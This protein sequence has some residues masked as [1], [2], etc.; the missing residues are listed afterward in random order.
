MISKE[1][2][3]E[4]LD[5]TIEA[6]NNNFAGLPSSPTIEGKNEA[7]ERLVKLFAL[8][9]VSWRSELLISFSEY[10]H[11]RDLLNVVKQ[12]IPIRVKLFLKRN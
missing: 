1:Q 8:N 10:L 9:N 4:I 3:L 6:E 7:V 12:N 5:D 2:I 11:K